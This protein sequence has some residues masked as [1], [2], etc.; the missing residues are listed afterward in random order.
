MSYCLLKSGVESSLTAGRRFCWNLSLTVDYVLSVGI[1]IAPTPSDFPPG[2]RG[3][4]SEPLRK[5][6]VL[7]DPVGKSAKVLATTIAPRK[8]ALGNI[9]HHTVV[10]LQS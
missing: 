2:A 1:Q 8:V 7:A 10:C 3:C 6:E 4:G 5:R 9:L